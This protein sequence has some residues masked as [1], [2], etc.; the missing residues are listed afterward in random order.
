MLASYLELLKFPAKLS[1]EDIAATS[2]KCL[3][4]LAE[5]KKLVD[6]FSEKQ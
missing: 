1:P 6:S 3:K 4:T 5:T 2:E